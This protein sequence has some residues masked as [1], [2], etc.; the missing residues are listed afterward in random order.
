MAPQTA[1][2]FIAN[3]VRERVSAENLRL[4]YPSETGDL[5]KTE[6]HQGDRTGDE[7]P[8][9]E[10]HPMNYVVTTEPVRR[11]TGPRALNCFQLYK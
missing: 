5:V 7:K 8:D 6:Q 2:S 10:K 3:S 11:M 4:P 1:L 9:I